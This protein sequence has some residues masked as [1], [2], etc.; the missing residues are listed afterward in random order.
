[1]VDLVAANLFIIRPLDRGWLTVAYFAL[2]LVP[3]VQNRRALLESESSRMDN[4][5]A[6]TRHR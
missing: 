6:K 5:E 2:Q 1:M 4:A 3:C